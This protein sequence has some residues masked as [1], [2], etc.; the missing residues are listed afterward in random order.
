MSSFVG[1]HHAYRRALHVHKKR[2][3]PALTKLFDKS[4]YVIGIV[5]VNTPRADDEVNV[6]A[7]KNHSIHMPSAVTVHPELDVLE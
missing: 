4:V 2:S 6:F 5:S 1:A 7:P 3:V